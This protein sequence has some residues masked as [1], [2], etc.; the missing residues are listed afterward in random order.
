MTQPKNTRHR[1]MLRAFTSGDY[2]RIDTAISELEAAND[3][4]TWIAMLRDCLI[5]KD[6][7]LIASEELTVSGNRQPA[8]DYG[9]LEL[10]GRIPKELETNPTIKRGNIKTLRIRQHEGQAGVFWSMTR[11]PTGIY[12]LPKLRSLNLTCAGFEM[13]PDGI[14]ALGR[15]EELVLSHNLLEKM[16]A[17]L[18]GCASLRLLDI[19][20]NRLT[21]L[22][23]GLGNLQKLEHLL[24][25]Y[26]RLTSWPSSLADLP[27]LEHLDL[28]FNELA[29]ALPPEI[30]RLKTLRSLFLNGNPGLEELPAELADLP[31]LNDLRVERCPALKPVPN[32]RNLKGE[33]LRQFLIKLRRSHGQTVPVQKKK[34]TPEGQME[35]FSGAS[36]PTPAKRY[37]GITTTSI[38]L[39]R[40]STKPGTSKA[41]SRPAHMEQAPTHE[42]L[43]S[44]L[45][46]FRQGD[47]NQE[48]AGMQLLRTLDD[49]DLY[50]AIFDR[51][52]TSLLGDKEP[53]RW[54]WAFRHGVMLSKHQILSLLKD[55]DNGFLTQHFDLST[56]TDLCLDMGETPIPGILKCF[57]KLQQLDLSLNRNVLPPEV[58]HMRQLVKVEINGLRQKR[59]L[60]WHNFPVLR[61][62]RLRNTQIPALSCVHCPELKKL[63]FRD[64]DCNDISVEQCPGFETLK[65]GNISLKTLRVSDP[66]P[67][68]TL[69]LVDVPLMQSIVLPPLLGLRSLHLHAQSN[70]TLL[71]EVFISEALE[72]LW[73]DNPPGYG[74]HTWHPKDPVPLPMPAS[75][76]LK[77]VML[78]N[79]GMKDFPLW[80]LD[81]PE[82]TLVSLPLNKLSVVPADWSHL[83]VLKTFDISHNLVRSLPPG[84][85]LPAS[86][87]NINLS[88]NRLKKVPIE[89]AQLPKLNRLS[90]GTQT[91][92]SL[93]DTTLDDIPSEISLKPGLKL[94][95]KLR[96]QDLRR[97]RARNAAALMHLGRPWEGELTRDWEKPSD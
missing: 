51:W 68:S 53:S 95:V 79:L 44:L 14:S 31:E 9:I 65:L 13:L 64:G 83:S 1:N 88:G 92:Q 39:G 57:P 91:N 69:E 38:N 15:L 6:G 55:N 24:L 17:D 47:K 23:A 45:S 12:R 84:I 71:K 89:L 30:G 49:D 58:E 59:P 19:G 74:S 93:S 72:V 63:I 97:M 82:L 2:D 66:S 40:P 35:L 16:P 42:L 29:P 73:I 32:R 28:S 50:R 26:N 37:Q 52:N 78:R 33:E 76:R 21:S 86:L 62:I 10:I 96:K 87:E 18:G 36:A 7:T 77:E 54:R 43:D 61:S 20:S 75:T 70:D 48:A 94:E 60:Q 11:F 41:E 67:I 25:K 27:A 8:A 80:L 90:L 46:Y 34:R 85:K 5:T 4:V 81:Q 3:E 56:V 22:P